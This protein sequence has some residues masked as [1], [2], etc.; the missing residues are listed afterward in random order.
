MASMRKRTRFVVEGSG[1]FP[2]DMLRY[3]HCWPESEGR[4]SP[5]LDGHQNKRQV[6]LLTDSQFAP[7]EGRWASFTWKVVPG[8]KER[9]V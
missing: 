1:T 7:T 2:Y 4:D 9:V 5:L 8:S 6:T 3:D